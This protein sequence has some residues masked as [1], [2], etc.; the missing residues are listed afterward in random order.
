M[1][2]EEIAKIIQAN[3]T[4][5]F[6]FNHLDENVQNIIIDLLTEVD[7]NDFK[8][9][10]DEG[11]FEFSSLP[12]PF[13]KLTLKPVDEQNPT[14]SY[15]L[16]DKIQGL[17]SKINCKNENYEYPSLFYRIGNYDEKY[18]TSINMS[19]NLQKTYCSYDWA[20]IKQLLETVKAD[21]KDN[22]TIALFHTHPN[23]F[24]EK[25]GT[26]FEKY[27]EQFS[28]LGVKPNGLNISLADIY[29]NMYLDNMLRELGLPEV[30]ES[31]ILMHDGR[32]VSFTTNKGVALTGNS[33]LEIITK[34]TRECEE[35]QADT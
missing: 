34:Q 16:L 21:D 35:T 26:L 22:F 33:M 1:T 6:I 20:T 24:G 28:K 11:N 5:K 12:I 25:Y 2:I 29:A 8:E 23:L 27:E 4:N 17:L 31:I 30:A 9:L 32:V 3:S 15:N 13:G 14:Y 7:A 10:N 18:N 19:N